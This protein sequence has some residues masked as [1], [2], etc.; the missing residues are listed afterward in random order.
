MVK[1]DRL[2]AGTGERLRQRS[3]SGREPPAQV[4]DGGCGFILGGGA[5]VWLQLAPSFQDQFVGGGVVVGGPQRQGDPTV[6]DVQ[7]AEGRR[8]LLP[9]SHNLQL[10]RFERRASGAELPGA[11]NRRHSVQQPVT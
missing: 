7:R 4:G 3:R 8:R 10:G 1:C 2:G 9:V 11:F 6:L 5:A